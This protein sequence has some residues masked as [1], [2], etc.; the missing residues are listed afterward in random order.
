MIAQHHLLAYSPHEMDPSFEVTQVDLIRP[1]ALDAGLIAKWEWFRQ[2]NPDLRSGY[3][4]PE[5]LFAVERVR[6]DVEIAVLRSNREVVGFFPFQRV[7][8][9]VADPVGGMMNDFHG[10]IGPPSLQL[11]FRHL[12]SSCGLKRFKFHALVEPHRD[13]D[14]FCYDQLASPH[15]D[16][17]GGY[18]GYFDNL[19][20]QSKTIRRQGQKTRR[21][22]RDHGSARFEWNVID[23]DV[24]ETAI[25]WKRE[26]YQRTRIFD[27]LS[28]DWTANLLREIHRTREPGFQGLLSALWAGDHLIAA[29]MGFLCG[30]VLHYWFPTFDY[31]QRR[32]SPGTQLLLQVCEHAAQRGVQAIELSYG[33]AGF[34]NRFSNGRSNVRIGELQ[35]GAV[36]HS[37]GKTRYQ[38]RQQIKKAPFKPLIKKVLRTVMPGFGQRA[39]R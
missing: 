37:L 30:T 2:S 4:H 33:E 38:A 32:Y 13:V 34:K 1:R 26:K 5:F 16:L 35:Y 6:S 31:S 20:S 19:R 7:A 39:F 8:P 21:M 14:R 22:V 23:P 10:V 25:R 28:V 29:H 24:L 15:I 36:S 9:Q 18:E 11:D 3:F 27:I 12:L 17:S